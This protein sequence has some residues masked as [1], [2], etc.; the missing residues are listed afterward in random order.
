ML[1][2]FKYL[3]INRFADGLESDYRHTFGDLDPAYE[4]TVRGWSLIETADGPALELTTAGGASCGTANRSQS[5]T[6]RASWYRGGFIEGPR[7]AAR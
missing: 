1:F 6:Y 5:C 4:T 2:N 3:T 7:R